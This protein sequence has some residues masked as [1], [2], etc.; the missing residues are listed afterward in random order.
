MNRLSILLGTVFLKVLF[1]FLTHV[2][3]LCNKYN[4]VICIGPQSVIL[5]H[6]LFIFLHSDP[7]YFGNSKNNVSFEHA[8]V[9]TCL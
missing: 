8:V 3:H 7:H 1:I 5:L 4:Y 2:N 6:H 9:V